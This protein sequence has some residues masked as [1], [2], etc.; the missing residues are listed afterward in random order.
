MELEIPGINITSNNNYDI[1]D[2]VFI[3]FIIV[4]GSFFM[5]RQLIMIVNH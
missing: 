4:N 2:Q 5:E 1:I 3:L